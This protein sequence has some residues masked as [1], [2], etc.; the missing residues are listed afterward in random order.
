MTTGSQRNENQREKD[1]GWRERRRRWMTHSTRHD[2]QECL[3]FQGS[4]L[5]HSLRILSLKQ[6][7]A[8]LYCLSF[9][10]S[11]LSR[12]SNITRTVRSKY[13]DIDSSWRRRTTDCESQKEGQEEQEKEEERE[14]EVSVSVRSVLFDPHSRDKGI[15]S[16]GYPFQLNRPSDGSSVNC[17]EQE[18]EWTTPCK[19]I[20]KRTAWKERIPLLDAL[21]FL[22]YD[23]H[24]FC[25]YYRMFRG[26]Q[27]EFLLLLHPLLLFAWIQMPHWKSLSFSPRFTQ[28]ETH[29]QTCLSLFQLL[30]LVCLLFILFVLFYPLDVWSFFE[31]T[32][33]ILSVFCGITDIFPA[34][35]LCYQE[36][37]DE[38]WETRRTHW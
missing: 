14:R 11:S 2:C 18:E 12:E 27:K 3:E 30:S 23:E 37:L 10:N 17:K 8:A 19:S 20:P 34:F 31:T 16:H 22:A 6:Q 25:F 29:W 9:E 28:N 15:Q 1:S 21:V 7:Q 26:Q 5:S 4:L 36:T 24:A 13:S 32:D 35:S 38:S 33:P